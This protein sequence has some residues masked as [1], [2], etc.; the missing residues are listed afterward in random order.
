VFTKLAKIVAIVGFV[1]GALR[2][3]MSVAIAFMPDEA[4]VAATARYLGSRPIGHYIDGSLY[5]VLACIALG[6]LAEISLSLR[7]KD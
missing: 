6:T 7:R 2:F 4:R 5:V 1:L 3:A